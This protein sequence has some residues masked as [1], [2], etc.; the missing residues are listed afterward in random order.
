MYSMDKCNTNKKQDAYGPKYVSQKSSAEKRG[1]EHITFIEKSKTV[2]YIMKSMTHVARVPKKEFQACDYPCNQIAQGALLKFNPAAGSRLQ[3]KEQFLFYILRKADKMRAQDLLGSLRGAATTFTAV[4]H[5]LHQILSKCSALLTKV[6]Q[7]INILLVRKVNRWIIDVL[8]YVIDMSTRKHVSGIQLVVAMIRL[9]RL[10][11]DTPGDLMVEQSITSILAALS[12]MCLPKEMLELVKRVS[13]LSATKLLEDVTIVHEFASFGCSIIAE[14]LSK[15]PGCAGLV[16]GCKAFWATV[17]RHHYLLYNANVMVKKWK[18]DRRI[19][20]QE[21]FRKDVVICYEAMTSNDALQDWQRMSGAVAKRMEDMK[22]LQRLALSYENSSRT[23]PICVVLEGPPGCFKSR[24]MGMLIPVLGKSV[25][26]HTVRAIGD[27]KEFFDQYGGEELMIMDDLG[28]GGPSQYRSLMNLVSPIKYPLDCASERLKFTKFF[29]S[30]AIMFTS[31]AFS[32]LPNLTAKDGIV[33]PTALWRRA[34]VFKFDVTSRNPNLPDGAALMGSITVR[35]YDTNQRQWITG[36]SGIGDLPNACK[37][38][39][40][41]QIVAWLADHFVRALRVK[42]AQAASNVLSETDIAD[43]RS[44][45][46][47]QSDAAPEYTPSAR[48]HGQFSRRGLAFEEDSPPPEYTPTM[49][50]THGGSWRDVFNTP[51]EV[52]DRALSYLRSR[53]TPQQV[54]DLYSEG[55]PHTAQMFGPEAQDVYQVTLTAD[56]DMSLEQVELLLAGAEEHPAIRLTPTVV[57]PTLRERVCSI[58]TSPEVLSGTIIML[59]YVA[60]WLVAVCIVNQFSRVNADTMQAQ[61]AEAVKTMVATGS[62]MAEAIARQTFFIRYVNGQGVE[63][64]S[65]GVI[66]GHYIICP[67]HAAHDARFVSVEAKVEGCRLIDN[68]PVVPVFSNRENDV[69]VLQLHASLMV[70]FK[71]LSKLLKYSSP[72]HSGTTLITPFGCVSIP[73]QY[74]DRAPHSTVSLRGIVFTLDDMNSVAYIPSHAG[75][76]GSLLVSDRSGV[77][78]SH[79]AGSESYGRALLWTP[80]CLSAVVELLSKDRLLLDVDIHDSQPVASATKLKLNFHQSTPSKSNIVGTLF[81]GVFGKDTK[82]PVNLTVPHL[83]K[84]V[85]KKSTNMIESVKLDVLDFAQ[86]YLSTIVEEYSEITPEEVTQGFDHVAKMAMDTSTGIGCLR[87]RHEYFVGGTYT[88]KLEKEI[89][90]L[91]RNALQ[92]EVVNPNLWIAKETLK[93]ETRGL[94]KGRMPR[95]FRVLRLPVNVLCKQLT[96]QMVNSLVKRRMSHGIMVGINPYQEWEDLHNKMR[97][98]PVIAADIKKFDGN[99]LPQVQ[100]M[101]RDVLVRKLRGS[102]ERKKL[103]DVILSSFIQNLVAVNDDVYLTTHSMPS[104]CYLTAIMNSLVHKA[105]TAMWYKT[106]VPEGTLRSMDKD[107]FDAVYGDDKLCI[108]RAHHDRL[109]ALTMRDFFRSIGLDLSTA[110]KKEIVE[111]F[112]KWEEVNFLKRTFEF[113]PAL[114]RVMCPLVDETILSMLSWADSSKDYDEVVQ[115]K[116]N[117]FVLESYLRKDGSDLYDRVQQWLESSGAPYNMWSISH[118]HYLFSK[119]LVDSPYAIL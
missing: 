97:A 41:R 28:Q 83:V 27:G 85:F 46:K 118:V 30:E 26:A 87:D 90:A 36:Y 40:D 77:L 47:E 89:A 14:C 94:A 37:L 61:S 92:D 43:I 75:L 68:A 72:C 74:Q 31:N 13:T 11:E 34:I 112:D 119:G 101:V 51:R 110:D 60:I 63:R 4:V 5:Y 16:A 65:A 44:R 96:G 70:P 50:N 23:E 79:V 3:Y 10:F 88:P 67:F 98:F 21:E 38:G 78:G 81:R 106:M 7:G 66:S 15:I 32:E 113:H 104:G 71:N 117:S 100:H 22:V 56:L 52:L 84:D 54:Q 57:E 64:R 9:Y 39:N 12:T 111:P 73:G 17:A 1:S 20:M 76:C 95:S 33:D 86:D 107:L 103:L 59:I 62:S 42:K 55:Y 102:Q 19:M 25:Y 82:E 99:M 58:L 69:V 108:V 29:N 18:A 93:D 116:L 91:E 35:T 53:L 105:Y 6:N 49:T 114:G 2:Y 8:L 109:N 115:G 45:M 24:Y 80:D 48:S